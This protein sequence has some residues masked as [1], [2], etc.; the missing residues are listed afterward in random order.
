MDF[1]LVAV[2]GVCSLVVTHR[3]LITAVS[4]VAEPGLAGRQASEVVG[5]VLRAPEHRPNNCGHGLKCPTAGGIFMDQGSNPWSPT[6]A[7]F[8]ITKP[9][10]KPQELS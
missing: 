7:G 9:P 2:S 6:L 1:S 10:G 4:L 3:L 8:F 5:S